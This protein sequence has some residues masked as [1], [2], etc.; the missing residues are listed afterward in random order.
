MSRKGIPNFVPTPE[1]RA[2][3]EMY[4]AVGIAHVQIAMLIKGKDGQPIS[5]DTL[6]RHFEAELELG[7][8]KT[9]A[10]IAGKLVALALGQHGAAPDASAADRLRAMMF[11]LNTRGKW[12]TNAIVEAP[13]ADDADDTATA[14]RI[15]GLLE[16]AARQRG[17]G[18]TIQ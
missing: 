18:K 6:T 9:V 8:S 17:A 5:V 13:E 4:A 15:A 2:Q 12:A 11:F 1:Q 7:L 16:K 14:A 10:M 3:V